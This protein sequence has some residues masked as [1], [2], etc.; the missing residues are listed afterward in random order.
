[1]LLH[2]CG[3]H[4]FFLL[5]ALATPSSSPSFTLFQ[6]LSVLTS[7]L[8]LLTTQ[9]A[10][11]NRRPSLTL[12]LPRL[13][14]LL[15]PPAL[16]FLLPCYG[17]YWTLVY[18]LF[19]H[20]SYFPSEVVGEPTAWSYGPK[21][22]TNGGGVTVPLEMNEA[23]KP[24][25]NTF[26]HFAWGI[27]ALLI[28]L[29]LL[30]EL[31]STSLSLP[32]SPAVPLSR[33]RRR[34]ADALAALGAL[35]TAQYPV[36]NIVKRISKH[37]ETFA[38]SSFCNNGIEWSLGVAVAVFTVVLYSA[39]ADAAALLKEAARGRVD[40]GAAGALAGEQEALSSAPPS[41]GG[42]SSSYDHMPPR[43]SSAGSQSQNKSHL[44]APSLSRSVTLFS[45]LLLNACYFTAVAMFTATWGSASPVDV[46]ALAL[47][48]AT[49]GGV[50]AGILR[51]GGGGR[52]GG[53]GVGGKEV[54]ER[55]EETGGGE[56]EL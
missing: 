19:L 24:E 43:N 34:T 52:E 54:G 51:G 8:A 6:C 7:T 5:Q 28:L 37:G 48:W 42:D 23:F 46:L 16:A 39:G 40:G 41:S 50:V 10:S 22:Y 55:G 30:P 49:W 20:P 26:V 21:E 11:S 2:S 44:S 9:A 32:A 18:R 36:Y 13:F 31:N 4:L 53:G 38:T 33:R 25:F 17:L 35:L 56:N 15:P 27:F 29:P 45:A 3:F 47:M 1:M 12:S 14:S